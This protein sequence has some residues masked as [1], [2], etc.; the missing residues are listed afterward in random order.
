MSNV[1]VILRSVTTE[2]RILKPSRPMASVDLWYAAQ[3]F[4]AGGVQWQLQSTYTELQGFRW[5]YVLAVNNEQQLAITADSI[6]MDARSVSH[7]A[8]DAVEGVDEYQSLRAFDSGDSF[9]LQPSSL[10]AFHILHFAPMLPCGI[11]LLGERDKW[12][13]ISEQRIASIDLSADVLVLE[14]RGE[15]GEQVSMDYVMRGQETAVLTA[16]CVMDMDGQAVLSIT[17]TA[18]AS[19]TTRQAGRETR[20]SEAMRTARE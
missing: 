18:A 6:H 15:P 10:P 3:A 2:G 9:T 20:R 16:S 13:R 12:V 11:A 14:L 1:S 7:V 5:H 8:W 19:C 17:A 4:T